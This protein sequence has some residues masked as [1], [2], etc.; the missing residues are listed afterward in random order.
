M[1]SEQVFLAAR[2][3]FAPFSSGKQVSAIVHRA[4]QRAGVHDAP[5][6][7]AH[8]LRHSAATAMLRAGGTLES[9]AMVLR[10]QSIQTT[11]HYAKVDVAMLLKVVQPWPPGAPC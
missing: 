1:S 5:T 2:P 4:L 3:P 10:H 7:G 11:A 6:Q 9:I 8:L